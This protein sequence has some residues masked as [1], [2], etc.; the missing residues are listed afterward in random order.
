MPD[1]SF[2]IRD[3]VA[4]PFAAVPTLAVH[5]HIQNATDEQVHSISLNCQTRI[6]PLGRTYSAEEEKRLLDLFGERERWARTMQP[7]PW[8][9]SVLKVPAFAGYIDLDLPLPCSFDF[10]V[11]ATKYFYGLGEG[12]I[13]ASIL[14]SGTAFYENETGSLQVAQVPWDREASFRVP[15]ATW[16]AAVDAHYPNSAWL[17]LS[18]ETFDRLFLYKLTHATPSWDRLIEHLLDLAHAGESRRQHMLEPLPAANGGR[19]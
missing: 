18:R 9:I 12:S 4:M 14:F 7:M 15:V 10:D 17:R 6:E 19:S 11:A 5:L 13:K 2:Q 3:V 8:N 16:Q 1:L